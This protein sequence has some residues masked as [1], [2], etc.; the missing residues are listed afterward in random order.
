MFMNRSHLQMPKATV[1]P[2]TGVNTPALRQTLDRTRGC[3]RKP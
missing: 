2:E 3:I 1:S